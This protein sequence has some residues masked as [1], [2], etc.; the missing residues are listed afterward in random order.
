MAR[1]DAVFMSTLEHADIMLSFAVK[2]AVQ[3]LDH[4]LHLPRSAND[5]VLA[6]GHVGHQNLKARAQHP[7][8]KRSSHFCHL[9]SV[10][11]ISCSRDGAATV[12]C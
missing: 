7:K 6:Q 10:L 3:H 9:A 2:R 11:G 4:T 1:Q 8:V 5:N 12:S